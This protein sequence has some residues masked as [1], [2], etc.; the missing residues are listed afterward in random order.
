MLVELYMV[1]FLNL[2]Y[3]R[4]KLKN[5]HVSHDIITSPSIV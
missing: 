2:F 3:N 5:G 1:I 4:K